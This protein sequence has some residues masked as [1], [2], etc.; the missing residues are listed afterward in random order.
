[1]REGRHNLLD[2]T[3]GKGGGKEQETRWRRVYIGEEKRI[4]SG[5]KPGENKKTIRK[6][7][8]RNSPMQK[9]DKSS[10]NP[11]TPKKKKKEAS[12]NPLGKGKN[13]C[14]HQA[15][16]ESNR[17]PNSADE[18]REQ[19]VISSPKGEKKGKLY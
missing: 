10:L 14:L 17:E 7:K 16:R 4:P 6:I 9:K 11:A 13:L 2:C 5:G 18:K 3:E 19:H 1:M 15:N 8:G 12:S